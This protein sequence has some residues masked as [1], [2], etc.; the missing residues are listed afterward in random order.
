MHEGEVSVDD[1][2]VR[3]LLEEQF[4]EWADEPLRRVP[5]SGTD[6]AIYRLGEDMGIR[7]PRIKWAE[8]QIEKECRWLPKLA[9]G[10]PVSVPVPLAKATRVATI[11]SPGWSIH[12]WK[13]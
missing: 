8:A 10:L 4:P 7:L 1:A 5:D 13:G 11:P 2:T 6:N 3:A 12:G 9:L